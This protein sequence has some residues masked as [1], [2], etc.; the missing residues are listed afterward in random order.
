LFAV[1][2]VLYAANFVAIRLVV[3]E[4]NPLWAA[5][6]RFAP[7]AAVLTF[8]T[9]G[10]KLRWPATRRPLTAT[11]L[12]GVLAFGLS[13]ALIYVALVSISSSIASV[14]FATVP[15][16][17]ILL[18]TSIG[19]ETLRWNSVAGAL[20]VI[21]GI[22]LISLGQPVAF[23]Q[24][25]PMIAAISAAACAAASTVILK[26]VPPMNP[27]AVNAVGMACASGVLLGAS[28]TLGGFLELPRDAM[29][30][31]AVL[32]LIISTSCATVLLVH[33][34]NQWTASATAYQ[35]VLSPP[36]TVILGV[37]LLG[38][39]FTLTFVA[40]AALLLIGVWAGAIYFRSTVPKEPR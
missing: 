38:E 7:S 40:G 2:I 33:V 34:L 25:V 30:W 9:V 27:V 15:L 37:S 23:G 19:Q 32:F 3:M 5:F 11:V 22:V 13:P 39:Q 6:L 10:G 12:Y 1:A 26:N 24:L 4:L 35:T 36:I 14:L 8:V 16:M 21:P 28:A 18:A 17:T 29:V 20:L 31:L